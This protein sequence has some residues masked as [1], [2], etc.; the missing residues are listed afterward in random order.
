MKEVRQTIG[1]LGN[2]MFKEAFI[3]GKLLDGEIPDLYLQSEKY[4][5]KHAETIKKRFSDGIGSTNAIS[6]HIRRGDYLNN[7]FYVD[8]WKTD[9][10]RRAVDVFFNDA[11]EHNKEEPNFLVF[12]RDNQGWEQ[13]KED[14]QWCR[15]NLTSLLGNR[16][17]L[18]PKENTEIDDFNLMASC[19]S[20]IGANSSFSWWA[21]YLNPNKYKT[22]I[23]PSVK[24]WYRDGFERTE[25]PKEW[26]RI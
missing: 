13:D 19:Y 18:P 12:C 23:M 6:L 3:T 4:W 16:F 1:G 26:I 11:K 5:E 15:D 14:R 10:Y 8:L 24:N 22:V 21:G 2:L 9:Y 25:C 20:N 17:E 7:D